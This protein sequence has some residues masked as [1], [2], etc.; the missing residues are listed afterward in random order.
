MTDGEDGLALCVRVSYNRLPMKYDVSFTLRMPA[1]VRDALNR[2]AL[3]EMRTAS[4]LVVK[5]L[6]DYLVAQGFLKPE[7]VGRGAV[8]DDA[9]PHRERGGSGTRRVTRSGVPSD[10]APHEPRPRR[11]ESGSGQ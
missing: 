8:P 3:R 11:R 7:D 6:A 9:A 5:V 1:V 4:S 2:A 10:D